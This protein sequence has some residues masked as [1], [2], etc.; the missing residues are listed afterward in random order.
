M[1]KR[2]EIECSDCEMLITGENIVIIEQ[3]G[4]NESRSVL[5]AVKCGRFGQYATDISVLQKSD[6]LDD[7]IW[8]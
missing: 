2:C 8:I 7:I 1:K 3:K 4:L 6:L 5:K